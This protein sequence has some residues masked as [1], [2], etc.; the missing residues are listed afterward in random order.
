MS[1]IA[2]LLNTARYLKWQQIY[3]R[4]YYRLKKPK[5]GYVKEPVLRGC[6]NG[7]DGHAFLK[8]AT[9]DGV[10]FTFLGESAVLHNEWNAPQHSKL[11]LYNLHY[12]DDLN[13]IGAENFTDLHIDLIQRWINANPPLL[14]NGWEPYCLSLRLVNWVKWFAR[15]SNTGLKNEWLQSMAIQALVLEQRLEYHVLGNHLFANAKALVFVGCYLGGKQ[16]DRWLSKG[17]RLL[18]REVA[19]QFLPDGAH[20]ELSPMYHATMLWDMC[21][22]VQLQQQTRLSCLCEREQQWCTVIS[23]GIEW[24]RCMVHPDGDLAFFNDTTLSVSPTLKQLED[25]ADKLEC[26]PEHTQEN[27]TYLP[28]ISHLKDSGYITVDWSENCRA[29]IDVAQVGPD[30]QPGHAHADTLSFELSL[31]GQRVFVNSGI[32]QYGEDAVR[33][34]QR[35]TAA[36]N[37][38]EINGENSSEVW[39]GFRVARRARP[40][41]LEIKNYSDSVTISA[42]HDGFMRLQGEVTHRRYWSTKPGELTIEDTLGGTFSKAIAYFHLHP[43][44]RLKQL[45]ELKW[46]GTL[47]HGQVFYITFGSGKVKQLQSSWHPKFG[48]TEQ[49]VCL[50]VQLQNSYLDTRILWSN[51]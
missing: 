4:L 18:D 48:V 23:K 30:Y 28:S 42:S 19:E 47:T 34:Y 11:W 31:F 39:A 40:F 26:L 46:R 9:Q 41:G 17:L 32:S 49:N 24:L 43:D 16:G 27:N 1:R 6:L 51:S 2:L 29:I 37:T 38:V 8:P 44:V 20:F 36:H 5:V 21:D 3:Y 50:S 10:H 15:R 13:A 12:Q 33:H 14:G 22:L 45:S 7:W 35:S 25:Y